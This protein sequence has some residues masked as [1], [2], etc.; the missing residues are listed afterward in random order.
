MFKIKNEFD[1][2]CVL[3]NSANNALN[4]KRFLPMSNTNRRYASYGIY[5]YVT[6]E[7][8]LF[9]TIMF[10]GHYNYN[11][12]SKPSE[13]NEMEALIKRAVS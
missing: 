4:M 6:K 3:A 10:S 5:D 1:R 9:D 13:F 12:N 8:V 2:I 7:Y 11:K